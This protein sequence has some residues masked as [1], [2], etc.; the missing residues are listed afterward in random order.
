M[1]GISPV[2]LTCDSDTLFACLQYSLLLEQFDVAEHILETGIDWRANNHQLI[3]MLSSE[4]HY[5]TIAALVDECDMHVLEPHV[6]KKV[7]TFRE[8][9]IRY[10]SSI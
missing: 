1:A 6:R 2:G 5:A 9:T 7:V 4:R 8:H 3:R 10:Y